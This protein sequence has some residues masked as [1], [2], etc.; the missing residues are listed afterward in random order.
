MLL[1]G[2]SSGVIQGGGSFGGGGCLVAGGCSVDCLGW[3]V[4]GWGVGG[5]VAVAE[6]VVAGGRGGGFAGAGV[7]CGMGVF[8]NASCCLFSLRGDGAVARGAFVV[9]AA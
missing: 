3:G 7:V 4:G 5:M 6:G 9:F 8:G 1:L 2:F